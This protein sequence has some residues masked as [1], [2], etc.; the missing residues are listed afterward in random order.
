MILVILACL[1]L[2]PQRCEVFHLPLP[3]GAQMCVIAGYHA[4]VGWSLQHPEWIVESWS[5][6]PTR[7]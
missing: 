3:G 2:E 5:C 7:A 4:V 1:A 6:G